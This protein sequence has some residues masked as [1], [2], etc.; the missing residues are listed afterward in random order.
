MTIPNDREFTPS[1]EAA[2]RDLGMSPESMVA[3]RGADVV[4]GVNVKTGAT[5]VFYGRPR[6][7]LIIASDRGPDGEWLRIYRIP[8]N[9]DDDSEE[10]E[11]LAALCQ[12][13]KGHYDSD[14]DAGP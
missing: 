6:L 12:V 1:E 8:I 2:M 9:F 5:T 14:E 10:P 4:L 3:F 11:L 13:V 7:K